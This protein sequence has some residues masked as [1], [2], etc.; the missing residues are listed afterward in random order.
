M[1]EL[2]SSEVPVAGLANDED[3]LRRVSFDIAGKPPT[4]RQVTLFGLNPNPN[5]R[6]EMIKQLLDSPDYGKNWGSYW[7]D[8]LFLSA[9]NM[10]SRI[11]APVFEEWMAEQLNQNRP[12]DQ[13]VTDLLTATGDAYENGETALMFAHGGEAEEVAAEACRIFLG[14]QIQCANCHDHP[15]D[16]WKREQFHELPASRRPA[17]AHRR[18]G[19]RI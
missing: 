18:H 10:R 3:F 13:I 8:V 12:W 2:T 7:R 9:T 14:I 15:S 11:A 1:D 4:P 17:Q 19:A 16:I 5:K 6:A